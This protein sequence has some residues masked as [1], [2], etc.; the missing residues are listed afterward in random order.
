[1]YSLFNWALLGSEV[2]MLSLITANSAF[3]DS[4]RIQARIHLATKA[5]TGEHVHVT[6]IAIIIVFNKPATKF[7]F[8]QKDIRSIVSSPSYMCLL[9]GS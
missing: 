2:K 7:W 8:Q 6:L 5:A 4:R 3:S 1:M 9:Y